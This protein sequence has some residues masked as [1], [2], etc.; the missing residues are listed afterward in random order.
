M[1]I[2]LIYTQ[3]KAE[4]SLRP[5]SLLQQM[6]IP[7]E[8]LIVKSGNDADIRQFAAFFSPKSTETWGE[9]QTTPPHKDASHKDA[10][11]Q[12]ASHQDAS[13]QNVLHQDAPHQTRQPDAHPE[14]PTIV[15]VLSSLPKRW[16]D[17]LAGFSVGSHLP[18]LVYGQDAISGIS[19]EFSFCFTF[20]ETDASFQLYLEAEYEVHKKQE[21]A[22][23]IISAQDTLLHFG[24]PITGEALAQCVEEGKLDEVK[25]FLAAG[26]SPDTRNKAG[27]PLLSLAARKGNREVSRFL[28]AEG[29]QINSR[30]DDR[31]TS[32][33]MDS[34]LRSHCELMAD[35]IEAGAD[36]N[37]KSK[38]GQTALIV[39]IGSGKEN[40]VE[41]LLKAGADPNIADSLG[42]N[43]REYATLFH[44]QKILYLLSV[45]APVKTGES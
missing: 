13:H 15:A 42:V 45:Y 2:L 43:A 17:F 22:R 37:I 27:V 33:L 20:V 23:G 39:A 41:A 10:S 28:I 8:T 35:F 38:D 16:C 21:A 12:D 44:N 24:I 6:T 11:H 32:A 18:I 36:A 19:E 40:I 31:G 7:S 30:A 25:L 26:F 5:L 29:A 14:N 3:E 4:Y 9:Q 34:V 1:K